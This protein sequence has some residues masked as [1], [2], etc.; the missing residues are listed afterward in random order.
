MILLHLDLSKPKL[1]AVS[2]C[3][4]TI[5]HRPQVASLPLSPTVT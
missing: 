1:Q 3:D 5:H 2:T 4:C